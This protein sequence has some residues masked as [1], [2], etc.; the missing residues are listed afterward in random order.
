VFPYLRQK[1][2]A[3]GRLFFRKV[4]MR[5]ELLRTFLCAVMVQPLSIFAQGS[6]TPP[7]APAATFK[8]LQQIE[9]RVDVQRTVNPL[10]TDPNY[11]FIIN[12]SGSYYLTAN[13][14]LTKPNAIHVTNYDVV[15]DLNGFEIS[16]IGTGNGITI[17][18]FMQGVTVKNGSITNLTNGVLATGSRSCTYTQL[19]CSSCSTGGLNV[20]DDSQIEGCK[21]LFNSG[22]GIITQNSATIS[23]C[24][25]FA[26]NNI[27]I[28][29]A[30][31]AVANCSS[32]SNSG[33]GIDVTVSGALQN[34]VAELNHG[35]RGIFAGAGSMLDHC[36]SSNNTSSSVLYGIEAGNRCVLVG[37]V[38]ESNNSTA[39]SANDSTGQG[40]HAGFGCV[41]RDCAAG[42]NHGAGIA[43][44]DRCSVLSCNAY[45]NGTGSIGSGITVGSECIVENSQFSGNQHYGVSYVSSCR[46]INNLASENVSAGFIGTGANNT[47]DGNK[48]QQNS[49]PGIVQA[50]SAADFI[51]RNI[52]Y[53]NTGANYSPVTSGA[54][55]GQL[56]TPGAANPSPWANF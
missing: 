19:V 40:I 47:V 31:G 21:V 24:T 50:S 12:Q 49:G 46:I 8:T 39:A 23:N 34:C 7:A 56:T 14:N 48:A 52:S 55:F 27:G 10:P 29:L 30:S 9:P 45:E 28:Q 35:Q 33:D 18:P 51:I 53:L 25:A 16:G 54:Y 15:I 5:T 22:S 11:M 26:N 38:A 1:K 20:G 32:N 2:L 37:C 44:A 3:I 17:D 36:V 41:L 6:L 42:L 43:V 4:S 13:I